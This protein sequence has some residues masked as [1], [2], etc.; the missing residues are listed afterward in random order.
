[1]ELNDLPAYINRGASDE[2]F[3]RMAI[4]AFDEQLEESAAFPQVYCLSLHTFMSGQPHRI[5]QLR[6]VLA[7]ITARRDRVWMTTPGAIA[8]H[9]ASLPQGTVPGV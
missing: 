1:M 4:D 8:A 2:E 5:R 3:S 9:I 6:T 7:H